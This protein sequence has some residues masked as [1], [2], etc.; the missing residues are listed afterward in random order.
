MVNA[1]NTRKLATVLMIVFIAT[2]ICA[3]V[4]AQAQ[5]V[6]YHYDDEDGH[7]EPW[8]EWRHT[9]CVSEPV[10]IMD[11]SGC[12][13]PCNQETNL[14]ITVW[15]CNDG[16]DRIRPLSYYTTHW[17]CGALIDPVRLYN[18]YLPF[19]SK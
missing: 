11:S 14:G 7:R 19:L 1:A 15:M 9:E 16:S 13:E 18:V 8:L 3:Y 10:V 6:G 12:D 5:T 17:Y 2:I 4:D